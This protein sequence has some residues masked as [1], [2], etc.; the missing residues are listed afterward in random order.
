MGNHGIKE[1]YFKSQA[2]R[3]WPWLGRLANPANCCW[4]LR[5]LGGADRVE[6]KGESRPF[7][8]FGEAHPES[9]RLGMDRDPPLLKAQG[10]DLED[11]RGFTR[12]ISC[13]PVRPTDLLIDYP[14][15][16]LSAFFKPSRYAR[17]ALHC[18]VQDLV[19]DPLGVAVAARP[20]PQAPIGGG[21]FVARSGGTG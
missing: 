9:F 14:F 5:A 4:G 20:P 3:L 18:A 12:G 8:V 7:R 16:S 15:G 1:Y 2:P 19:A 21:A 6:R 17:D 13:E 10:A 11:S